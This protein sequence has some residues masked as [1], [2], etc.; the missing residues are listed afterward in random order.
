[1]SER[2]H[3]RRRKRRIAAEPASED[4]GLLDVLANLVGVL[5]MFAAITSLLSAS[6]DIRIRTPM[7]KSS[8]RPL[9][10]LQVSKAGV[11]DLQ[12]A[13]T[14]MVKADRQRAAEVAR[15]GQ[16]E[17]AERGTCE[18]ELDGWRYNQRLASSVVTVTHREGLISKAGVPTASVR[19][20]K[21]PDGWLDQ[22]LARLAREKKGLFILLE[23]DGFDV[24][25]TIKRKAHEQQVP[26][27]WE[28]WF[29]GDPV[30]FWGNSGRNL[31]VQ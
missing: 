22:Q 13:V 26:V 31:T 14:A 29:K 11:W 15:C 7:N 3:R 12:P 18:R 10:I 27:G 8:D 4:T 19:A 6:G 2:R 17:A 1:M 9:E 20:L 30:Y 5:A 28:P 25:R 16:L 23:N 21:Q 24:Y